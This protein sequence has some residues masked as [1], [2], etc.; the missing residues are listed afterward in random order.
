MGILARG[1]I[2]VALSRAVPHR[3]DEMGGKVLD[4]K[5]DAEG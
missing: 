2:G 5:G 3:R 1:E 4:R